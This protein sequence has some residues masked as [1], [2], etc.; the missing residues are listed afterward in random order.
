MRPQSIRDSLATPSDGGD[1]WG[2]DPYT[3][4]LDES[5]N[6]DYGDLRLTLTSP[7][8]NA[9]DN[10][11]LPQDTSD[12]DGDGN[13]TEPIP[14]DLDGNP[15]IHGRVVDMGAYEATYSYGNIRYVDVDATRPG[16]GLSWDSAYQD[17]QRALDGAEMMNAADTGNRDGFD[18]EQIWIAEGTYKPSAEREPGDPRSAVFTLVE[19]VAVFGGFAGGEAELSER[20]LET[21]QTEL[22][23]DIGQIDDPADNA[24]TVVFCGENVSATLDGVLVTGG[25]ADGAYLSQH[26]E[27][28]NGGGVYIDHGE[29]VLGNTIVRGNLAAENGGGIHIDHGGLTMA[30]TV[31]VG[32]SAADGGAISNRHGSLTTINATLAGNT[33]VFGGGVYLSPGPPRPRSWSTPSW[34]TMIRLRP[35][36]TSTTTTALSRRPIHCFVSATDKPKSSTEKTAT[37]LVPSRTRSIRPSCGHRPTRPRT[38]TTAICVCGPNPGRSTPATRPNCRPTNMIWT[39]TGS[40]R[41]RFLTIWTRATAFNI[42]W[43]IWARMRPL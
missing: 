17:L 41:N 43:L 42:G 21:H 38:T 22:S 5:A 15:R 29:L 40:R 33:A 24:Y 36:R 13:T 37:S 11:F 12:M 10:A 20:D 7:A 39:E 6:D 27:R 31:L 25:T 26:Q 2:D 14:F 30:N 8:V 28:R 35:H 23:G 34:P 18:V 16:N 1:G 19:E 4:Y 3:Q 9:G 32:N